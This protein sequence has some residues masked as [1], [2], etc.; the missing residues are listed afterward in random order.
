MSLVKSVADKHSVSCNS[1]LHEYKA[2]DAAKIGNMLF[3]V[4]DLFV[5]HFFNVLISIIYFRTISLALLLSMSNSFLI[6]LDFVSN[7]KQ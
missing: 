1:E 5:F 7:S 6:L 2:V 3:F 4:V